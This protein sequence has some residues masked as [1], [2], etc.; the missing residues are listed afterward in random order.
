MRTACAAATI[1]AVSGD[2]SAPRIFWAACPSPKSGGWSAGAVG[3]VWSAAAI[4]SVE[5]PTNRF[6]PASTVFVHSVVSRSVTHGTPAKYASR[7]TPPESVKMVRAA[8][9][10]ATIS[11]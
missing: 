8:H 3:G 4:A 6:Q 7:W 5:A 11:R 9:S 10:R 1:S 2:S